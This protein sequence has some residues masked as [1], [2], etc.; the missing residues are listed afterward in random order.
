LKKAIRFIISSFE[1]L[2]L[3]IRSSLLHRVGNSRLY[4]PL[5]SRLQVQRSF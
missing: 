4:K 2:R 5:H 1:I 3:A